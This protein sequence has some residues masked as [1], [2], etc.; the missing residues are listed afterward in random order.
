MERMAEV[1]ARLFSYDGDCVMPSKPT[2][3]ATPTTKAKPTT[4][5]EYLAALSHDKRA[6]LEGLRN[7]IRAAAP[8]VE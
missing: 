5:D 8:G 1:D 6:A 2:T 7:I 3:K 4:V